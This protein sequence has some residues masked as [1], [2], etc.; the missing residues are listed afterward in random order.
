M[1]GYRFRVGV[2]L[3]DLKVVEGNGDPECRDDS[4]AQR[5]TASEEEL[6]RQVRAFALVQEHLLRALLQDRTVP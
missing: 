1:A 6:D 3:V 5:I 2:V 4:C